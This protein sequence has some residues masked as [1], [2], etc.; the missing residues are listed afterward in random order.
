MA[1]WQLCFI[2]AATCPNA[3]AAA[4]ANPLKAET[5]ELAK[6]S[7]VVA[8]P[9][10]SGDVSKSEGD[11]ALGFTTKNVG[12]K[13]IVDHVTVASQAYEQGLESGD[14]IDQIQ[15]VSPS[16]T[17]VILRRDDKAYEIKIVKGAVSG[18]ASSSPLTAAVTASSPAHSNPNIIQ[19]IANAQQK[20]IL[21]KVIEV[22]AH[23][24]QPTAEATTGY[25]W[26]TSGITVNPGQTIWFNTEANAVW[27]WCG[28]ASC[29]A[30]GLGSDCGSNSCLFKQFP[31]TCELIGLLTAGTP[32]GYYPGQISWNNTFFSD[33]GAF[34]VGDYKPNIPV[35]SSG[36]LYFI[37]NDNA[38]GD[39]SGTVQV[40]VIV[41][42]PKTK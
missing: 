22:H 13:Q 28:G 25:P 42:E 5:P 20:I 26:T 36:R 9:V 12:G 41:T 3:A 7:S 34:A 31:S 29:D 4:P 30:N 39:N 17:N 40:R 2:F 16:Q 19:A 27:N 32:P 6:P 10:L 14:E 35:T 15:K 24:D 33:P 38:L 23:C 18:G 1:A 21:D 37:P 11:E 8:T